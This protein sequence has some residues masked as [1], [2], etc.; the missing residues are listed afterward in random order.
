MIVYDATVVTKGGQCKDG[1]CL[2]ADNIGAMDGDFYAK[3]T[4]SYVLGSNDP[5]LEAHRK[6]KAPALV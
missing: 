4:L 3:R 2:A 6:R 5:L 1:M